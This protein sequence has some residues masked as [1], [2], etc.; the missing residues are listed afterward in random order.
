MNR[1]AFITAFVGSAAA[2]P[3]GA[4]A[5]LARKVHQIGLL[6]AAVELGNIQAFVQRLGE[7]GY[8]DGRNIRILYRSAEGQLDRLPELAADLVREKVDVIVGPGAVARAARE[9]TRTIPIVI[10]VTGDFVA[11]GLAQSLRRPGGNITG[12]STLASGLLGKQL[13]LLQ[14][15]VPGLS[16]VAVVGVVGNLSHADQTRRAQEAAS[17]LGLDIVSI[18]VKGSTDLP[19]AFHR[20]KTERVDGIVVLRSG[21]LLGMREQMVAH[22]IAAK[23]PTL[24]GHMIEAASGGLMAYGAD[25]KTLF[26]E[27]ATYVDKILKGADPAEL[28]ISQA[29]KF[30]LTVNLRT[31]RA[32]GITFPRSILLRADTVIE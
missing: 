15:T 27:A 17:V 11:Q 9:A 20:M 7:L 6:Y 13:E 8:V 25:T 2:W 23:L 29:R 1:R 5:Q 30:N 12:L 32:L 10:A 22:A 31:A 19:A 18:L 16:R 3:L 24:F 4:H 26:R 28:P 14:E 21:F